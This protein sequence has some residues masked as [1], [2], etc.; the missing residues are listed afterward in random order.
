MI[1]YGFPPPPPGNF[2]R[3]S[4]SCGGVQHRNMNSCHILVKST[5]SA[6]SA[7]YVLPLSAPSLPYLVPSVWS[8]KPGPRLQSPRCASRHPT[9]VVEEVGKVDVCDGDGAWGGGR[10]LARSVGVDALHWRGQRLRALA[11]HCRQGNRL[12][13]KGRNKR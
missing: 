13:V 7:L 3:A 12:T 10:S 9:K 8:P 6:F 2:L 1:F 5:S 11:P 4:G